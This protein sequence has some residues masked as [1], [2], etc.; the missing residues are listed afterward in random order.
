[1]QGDGCRRPLPRLADG[2]GAGRPHCVSHVILG[3]AADHCRPDSPVRPGALAGRRARGGVH[4]CL[5]AALPPCHGDPGR[6]D[7]RSRPGCH[8]WLYVL[9]LV[10][11]RS[12]SE[13]R[14]TTPAVPR[15]LVPLGEYGCAAPRRHLAESPGTVRCIGSPRSATFGSC[16]LE[17]CN[18][19]GTDDM[20][21]DSLHSLLK[22]MRQ[23][24]GHGGEP[25]R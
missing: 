8:R 22:S 24:C 18:H 3:G 19:A 11:A 14:I 15:A 2:G 10:H 25:S 1:M 9:C 4:G 20:G 6:D 21:N 12:A 5:A 16:A 13:P 17:R 23:Y 7:R